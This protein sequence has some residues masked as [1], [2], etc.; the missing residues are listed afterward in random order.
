MPTLNNSIHKATLGTI[1]CN[2]RL[3]VNKGSEIV[4]TGIH[5]RLPRFCCSNDPVAYMQVATRLSQQRG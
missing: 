2:I 5:T 3:L 4:V 1:I